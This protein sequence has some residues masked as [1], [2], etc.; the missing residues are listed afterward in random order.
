[1]IRKKLIR[2]SERYGLA[3]GGCPFC[4]STLPA[5]DVH[6]D[7]ATLERRESSPDP[8]GFGL[9]GIVEALSG[10]RTAPADQPG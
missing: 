10:D 7:D 4:G 3:F 1:M 6:V 2:N 5:A 9:D 8:V